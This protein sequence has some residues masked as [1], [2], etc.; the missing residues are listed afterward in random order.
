LFIRFTTE[1][2][3]DPS[4]DNT[5]TLH[6]QD[7]A[8]RFIT[9]NMGPRRG[10][11]QDLG[12]NISV[13]ITYTAIQFRSLPT[14]DANEFEVAVRLD[15][16]PD[17]VT[18][19]FQ[20][21]SIIIRIED[22]GS[23]DRIPASGDGVTYQLGTNDFEEAAPIGFEK[24]RSSDLRVA[25]YNVLVDNLFEPSRQPG[26]GRQLQ[27]V[28]PDVINFQEIFNNT[29]EATGAL[30]E[31][32]LPLEDGKQWYTA[33]GSSSSNDTI[34]VSRF[35]I[36]DRWDIYGSGSTT[37]NIA[38]L[39][40]TK[41]ELGTRTLMI[42]AHP[43]AG[44]FDAGRQNEIDAIM[45][46]IRDAREPDGVL[47]IEEN[48]PIVIAGDM[49]LVGRIDQL[50]TF[51]TGDISNNDTQ[52]ADFSPDWDG[53]DLTSVT[54]R[55]SDQRMGYT[56]RS[57]FENNYWPGH[58][59][60]LIYS[61]SVID[62]VHSYVVHTPSM[63]PERLQQYNLEANDSLGSDHFLFVADFRP[64]FVDEDENGLPDFWEKVALG[65]I[66][67]TTASEDLDFDGATNLEEYYAG[68]DPKDKTSQFRVLQY[69]LSASE[70][71]I[72]WSTVSQRKYRLQKSTDLA[73]WS[74]ISESIQGTGQNLDQQFSGDPG[75]RV[76]YRIVAD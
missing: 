65:E 22:S 72:H 60:Y 6:I 70:V 13:D 32:W 31:S 40:D 28:Q 21:D 11:F 64:A 66:D 2:L 61:D 73:N 45:A 12:Q 44:A 33:G 47:T 14:L 63:S 62:L 7:D 42:N 56:W 5:M 9:W 35:P 36:L 15:A 55:H 34:T 18:S 1:S 49:N 68:T 17:G 16:K 41:E 74:D 24:M 43:P 59:D 76:F 54:P 50:V 10:T 67:T 37:G 53:S 26:F 30:I 57:D 48:T 3:V 39:L 8:N 71:S 4:D 20:D 75:D 19:L 69:S 38:V 29:P 52:G 46:F 25:T 27:A 23:G 58:L 51:L